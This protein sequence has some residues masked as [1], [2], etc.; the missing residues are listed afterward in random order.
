MAIRSDR[1]YLFRKAHTSLQ[2]VHPTIVGGSSNCT[3]SPGVDFAEAAKFIFAGEFEVGKA[4]PEVAWLRDPGLADLRDASIKG[5][6]H[7]FYLV[8]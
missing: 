7:L 1:P 4:S 6:R 3:L 2:N 8:R 5:K